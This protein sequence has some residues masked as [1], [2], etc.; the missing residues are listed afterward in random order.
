MKRKHQN[1][2]DRPLS[3]INHPESQA[4]RLGKHEEL[5]TEVKVTTDRLLLPMERD[6]QIEDVHLIL[7]VKTKIIDSRKAVSTFGH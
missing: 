2:G 6:E 7:H 5:I 1:E 4:Q 3:V